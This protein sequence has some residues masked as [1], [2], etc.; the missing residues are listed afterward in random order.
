[1]VVYLAA[2]SMAMNCYRMAKVRNN[3]HIWKLTVKCL[4]QVTGASIRLSPPDPLETSSQHL[5]PAP[6]QRLFRGPRA[7]HSHLLLPKK[8]LYNW[9]RSILIRRGHQDEFAIRC[10]CHWYHTGAG[11]AFQESR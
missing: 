7:I 10:A 11:F 2:L 9:K 1:M 6:L 4:H 3:Q 5:P 8:D